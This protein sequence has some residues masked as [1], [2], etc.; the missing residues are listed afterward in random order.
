MAN[1]VVHFEV[2]GTNAK[3]TQ[4]FYAAL[5]GWKI[6]ADNPVSYGLVEKGDDHGI[7]GGLGS[8]PDGSAMV[9]FYVEVDDLWPHL[10]RAV[11]LGGKVVMPPTE[12]MQQV[13]IAQFADPDGNVIGLIRR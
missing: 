2:I 3:R 4:D 10:D 11:S 9:T 5:F 6:D 12:V 7:A 8:G 13:N 1:P